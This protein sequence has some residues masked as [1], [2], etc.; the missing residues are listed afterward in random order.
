M[1][2]THPRRR[3]W[4]AVLLLVVAAVALALLAV[5]LIA[6]PAGALAPG[7]VASGPSPPPWPAG[8]ALPAMAVV[9]AGLRRRVA[10]RA[11]PERHLDDPDLPGGP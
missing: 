11:R 5:V 9:A 1:H 6:P 8:A 4:P 10:G 3:P 7:G 2:P